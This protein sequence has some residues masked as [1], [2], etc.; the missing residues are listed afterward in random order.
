MPIS[1]QIYQVG[2]STRRLEVEN[3]SIKCQSLEIRLDRRSSVKGTLQVPRSTTQISTAPLAPSKPGF[4]VTL[5]TKRSG[6]QDA[7]NYKGIADAT[8]THA[9]IEVKSFALSGQHTVNKWLI[10]ACT[11]IHAGNASIEVQLTKLAN[12]ISEL[13]RN[14][15]STGRIRKANLGKLDNLKL[16]EAAARSQLNINHENLKDL[17]IMAKE[18]SVSWHGYFDALAAIYIRALSNKLG[19]DVRTSAAEV[20]PFKSIEIV[21]TEDSDEGN[22]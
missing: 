18:A 9:L 7:K 12:E 6:R 14:P 21:D 2:L 19:R 15:G 13:K 3:C 10:E 5:R 8:M 11:S 16:E 4:W 20:P 1:G 17:R 22:A